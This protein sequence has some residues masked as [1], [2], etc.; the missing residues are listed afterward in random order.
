MKKFLFVYFLCI[1]GFVLSQ[2]ISGV[3]V[4]EESARL[5]KTLVINITSEQKIWSND[6]GEFSINAKIGDEIRFVKENYERE[7]V[8]VKNNYFLTVRLIKMP[9]EIE[10]VKISNIKI[11][12]DINNDASRLK[13]R[14][15]KEE[16]RQAI[17]LPKAPE[18]SRE[19][20]ADA[21]DDVLMPFLRIPPAVNIQ[22][23]YDVVS[24]KSKKMKRLYKYEDT[25][26][27][28]K[29]IR[30]KIENNYFTEA[31]IPTDKIND[32]ILFSLQDSS[33]ARYAKAKNTT[34]LITAL[35]QQIPVF[36]KRITEK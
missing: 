8:I 18:K 31:G 15:S 24:G 3:V 34:G 2:T 6:M 33:V 7:R 35:E 27:D 30:S 17:G 4:T 22:G 23:I 1:S 11:T 21:V 14:D 32:F 13:T 20:P 28:I 5:P 29:W 10:E 25:Q 12:G 16:L 9:L 19:K 36:L 26:D